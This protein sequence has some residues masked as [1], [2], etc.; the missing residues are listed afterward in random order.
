MF[1]VLGAV[2]LVAGAYYL[3]YAVRL[4]FRQERPAAAPAPALVPLLVP[5]AGPPPP[6]DTSRAYPRPGVSDLG[7]DRTCPG[8][9]MEDP[10][11]M[12]GDLLGWPAHRTCAE[13]SGDW[14]PADPA[15]AMVP[16][17][18]GGSFPGTT[19]TPPGAVEAP[20][21]GWFTF[22]PRGEHGLTDY[23]WRCLC[24]ATAHGTARTPGLAY[25]NAGDG[26]GEH[27]RSRECPAPATR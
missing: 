22:R 12:T 11:H 23:H 16:F 1:Q 18:P 10:G 26:L 27:Q 13:L 7:L 6:R 24:G 19:A 4:A 25:D 8:C 20:G 9:G 15:P 3:T 2:V 21:R 17:G 5:A 14:R